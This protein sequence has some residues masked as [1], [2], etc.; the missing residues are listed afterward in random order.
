[1]W[2]STDYEQALRNA[3]TLLN[4]VRTRGPKRIILVSDFQAAG[5]NQANATFRL[6][7]D[8]QLLTFDVGGNPS[9]NV[10]ITDVEARS[11]NFGQKYSENLAVH[12]SNFSDTPRDHLMITFQMNDQTVEKREIGLTAREA[13]VVEFTGFNLAE[14][15]SRCVIDIGSGDFAADNRFYF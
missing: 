9:P 1:G 6:G 10:A 5:W 8:V 13:K 2:E 4:E 12:V 7:S 3:D 14:G 11:V 15:V